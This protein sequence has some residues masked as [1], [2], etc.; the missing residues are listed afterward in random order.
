MI[1]AAGDEDLEGTLNGAAGAVIE[2]GLDFGD[3]LAVG[4]HRG[5]VDANSAALQASAKH[6]AFEID[7]RH[8]TEG[9]EAVTHGWCEL[10][11]HRQ[12]R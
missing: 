8:E 5:R 1:R 12:R 7:P 3:H 9:A 11:R 4:R 10:P 2:L 6:V